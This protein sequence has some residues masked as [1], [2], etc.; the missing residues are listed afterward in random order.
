MATLNLSLY[1]NITNIDCSDNPNLQEL[2]ISNL[3]NVQ[4]LVYDKVNLHNLLAYN[5]G[6]STIEFDDTEFISTGEKNY[7]FNNSKLET[8]G[9]K[10]TLTS[11]VTL[12]GLGQSNDYCDL[13][14]WIQSKTT[15]ANL[16]KYTF[17]NNFIYTNKV[18]GKIYK[19]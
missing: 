12:Y 19:I 9:I 11:T 18:E 15:E 2:D 7:I 17:S 5:T 10:D 16:N 14:A 6:F 13:I 4:S 3:Q 1:T 8:V